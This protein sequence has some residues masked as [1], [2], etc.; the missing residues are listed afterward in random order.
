MTT[1][2]RRIIIIT[3]ISVT[4]IIVI[5]GVI[6]SMRPSVSND[7]QKQEA[8]A[9]QAQPVVDAEATVSSEP[10]QQPAPEAPKDAPTPT[11]PVAPT[12]ANSATSSAPSAPQTVPHEQTILN[13]AIKPADVPLVYELLLDEAGWRPSDF[14]RIDTAC[15]PQ[16]LTSRLACANSYVLRNYGNWTNVANFFRANGS[17]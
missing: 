16:E 12:Q 7:D 17:F 3:A 9:V 11:R 14:R 15:Q 2:Q 4:A 8:N 13:A 10:I 6:A 5:A 1:K